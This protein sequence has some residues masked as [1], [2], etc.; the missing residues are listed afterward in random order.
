MDD[1]EA[2]YFEVYYPKPF[3]DA[4]EK[5]RF[6][7]LKEEMRKFFVGDISDIKGIR[8]EIPERS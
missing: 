8:F 2:E 3:A 6:N 1:E 7:N 4:A 5:E